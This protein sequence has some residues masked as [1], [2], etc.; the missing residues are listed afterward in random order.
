MVLCPSILS[1]DPSDFATPVRQMMEAGADYIHLDVMDGQ[2]VPPITFGADLASSLA[3]LGP[4]PLEAHLMTETPER[5]FDA[6]V[7]AGCRRITFHAEATAHAHRLAQSLRHAGVEAGVA[8]N[9]GTSASVLEALVHDVDLV[10]VMTVNPGW[11]GQAL[12]ESCVEKVRTVRRMR[13]D[14]RI[15]VDGGVDPGTARRLH[16][17]GATDFVAGSFVTKHGDIAANMRALRE[18]CA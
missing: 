5:H 6:F 1:C 14:V 11:G 9:P 16:D 2:F 4:T 12:V 13:P 17:A 3:K 10:L 18:A 15:Q 7:A 8:V